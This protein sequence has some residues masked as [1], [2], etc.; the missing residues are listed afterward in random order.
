MGYQ[1]GPPASHK[2]TNAKVV[3]M[4]NGEYG[5]AFEFDSGYSTFAQV[6]DKETADWYAKVQIGEE[7]QFG[8][9]P[10]LLNSDKAKLRDKKEY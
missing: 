9:D 10:L 1:H 3:Q 7:I 6:G 2:I 5:I 4:D 8:V